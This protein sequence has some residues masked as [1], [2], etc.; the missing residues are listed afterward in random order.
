MHRTLDIP[1]STAESVRALNTGP[2]TV[3][4]FKQLNGV[5]EIHRLLNESVRVFLVTRIHIVHRPGTGKDNGRDG[6]QVRILFEVMQNFPTGHSRHV[7]V[8]KHYVGS[9][10]FLEG[11]PSPEEIE[12]SLPV[13]SVFTLVR[14]LQL[15]H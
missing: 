7:E 10:G 13:G 6:T 11:V 2:E 1:A 3:D 9:R 12:S 15:P 14:E 4:T 8:E 5:I